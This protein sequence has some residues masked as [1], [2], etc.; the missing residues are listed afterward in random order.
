AYERGS[1][2]WTLYEID[3][4]VPKE[5]EGVSIRTTREFCGENCTLSGTFFYDDFEIKEL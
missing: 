5:S 2:D 4:D 1:N 3:F